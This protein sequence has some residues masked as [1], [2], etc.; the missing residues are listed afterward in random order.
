MRDMG[1]CN[2]IK[3]DR[4]IQIDIHR[5][6]DKYRHIDRHVDRYRHA[7]TGL[8]THEDIV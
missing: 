8:Q 6:T 5:H 4:G 1:T 2:V 7:H 3:T